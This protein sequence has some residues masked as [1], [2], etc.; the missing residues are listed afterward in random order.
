MIKYILI[1]CTILLTPAFASEPVQKPYSAHP[2]VR[3][4]S[5]QANIDLETKK[6]ARIYGPI[7]PESFDVFEKDMLSTA[8]IPGDRIIL[9]N[10]PGGY[11]ETGERMLKLMRME[12]AS[13]TRVVCF[14]TG[15]ASSMAF[16]FLTHCDVRLMSPNKMSVVH[17]VARTILPSRYTA[18][19]LRIMADEIDKDDE[20]YRQANAKAMNLTLAQY[21]TFAD[22]E[23]YWKSE[24]LLNMGYLHGYGYFKK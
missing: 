19:T 9:I 3:V 18:K 10:S 5:P 6:V 20:P 7:T 8:S 16:N 24:T 11:I 12:K 15:S 13:G 22:L 1:V 23:T 2:K 4:I 14:V 17:K 21:D